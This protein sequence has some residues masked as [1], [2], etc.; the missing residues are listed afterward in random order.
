MATR[1]RRRL[2]ALIVAAAALLTV[3]AGAP[4]DQQ[5]S[6]DIH[7][8]GHAPKPHHVRHHKT[9]VAVWR[10]CVPG[11]RSARLAG[12]YRVYDDS[13]ATRTCIRS[14]GASFT[15]TTTAHPHADNV[16]SYPDIQY[17]SA[18]GYTTQ[19]SGLPLRLTRIG[20]PRLSATAGGNARGVWI[21]DFDSWFFP[22]RNTRGHGTA[23]L[24]IVLR[25][26]GS[27]SGWP[28]VR[29][30]GREYWL[31]YW[32]TCLRL[33]SGACSDVWWPLTSFHAVRK[34]RRVTGLRLAAFVRV[35][36]R[37]GY[38]PRSDWWGSTDFGD[39][40]WWGGRRLSG[41]MRVK[42]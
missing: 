13:W 22:T 18:Y 17:G 30:D 36:E 2:L 32:I 37:R 35:A 29:V 12:S 3:A 14:T 9:P 8:H 41:S 38:L 42:R 34:V 7:G 24:T 26:P 27:V 25:Y 16:V 10:T 15:V 1:V 33:P 4:H 39:E 5:P 40:I 28:R 21:A 31:E 20:S 23:E 6:P 11:G 19:G